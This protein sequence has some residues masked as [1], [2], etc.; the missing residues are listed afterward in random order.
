MLV[1]LKVFRWVKVVYLEPIKMVA[2]QQS[3][4]KYGTPY[5]MSTSTKMQM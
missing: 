2:A 3:T 1:R 5:V 4:L